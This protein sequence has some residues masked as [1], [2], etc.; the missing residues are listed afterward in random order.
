MCDSHTVHNCK[1]WDI[2]VQSIE[3]HGCTLSVLFIV[4]HV[5]A[6]KAKIYAKCRDQQFKF[7]HYLW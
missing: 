4:L 6:P 2:R 7:G 5:V 3:L 1:Y